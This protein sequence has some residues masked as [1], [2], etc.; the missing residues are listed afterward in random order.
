MGEVLVAYFS[1]SGITAG[2]AKRLA[3][4]TDADLYEI[5]PAVP[6]TTKDLDWK[7][8]HS[9]SNLEMEDRSSRPEI[10]DRALDI[11]SYDTI[12][13]GFPIWWGVAPTIV[14]TFLEQYD[15]TGKTMIPFATSGS[16]GMGNTNAELAGSCP[17]A[18]L[19]E[20]K[21]FEAD[22]GKEELKEWI[23]SL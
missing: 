7:D 23:K 22:A 12:Y 17:G 1:A 2:V 13:L 18:L 6:Y 20:G 19:K 9:R 5:R 3:D 8:E 14:L 16:S 15:W 4:V 11:A 10:Q 21:R